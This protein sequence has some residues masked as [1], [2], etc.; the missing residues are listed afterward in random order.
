M[1]SER[2]HDEFVKKFIDVEED[3]ELFFGQR[4]NLPVAEIQR[5]VELD[6]GATVVL[7]ACNTGRG[8]IKAEGVMGPTRGLFIAGTASTVVSLWSADDGSTALLMPLMYPPP[9]MTT[10]HC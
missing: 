3:K 9:H 5:D 1:I 6:S 8:E 10:L 2:D 4:E 7:S